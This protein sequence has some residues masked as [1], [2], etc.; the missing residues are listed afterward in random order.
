MDSDWKIFLKE[1][2]LFTCVMVIA[3]LISA[4]LASYG[5]ATSAFY[6]TE[7]MTFALLIIVILLTIIMG[8]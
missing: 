6:R 2:N 5:Y 4:G 1:I 7:T 8:F 3:A